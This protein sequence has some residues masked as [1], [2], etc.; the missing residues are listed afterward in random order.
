MFIFKSHRVN[1]KVH[2]ARG[3]VS[4]TVITKAMP[5]RWAK[6]FLSHV[7]HRKEHGTN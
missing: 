6:I 3:L 4:G 7:S 1:A 2:K 5:Q